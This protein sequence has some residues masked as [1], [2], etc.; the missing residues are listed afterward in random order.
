LR[1]TAATFDHRIRIGNVIFEHRDF[2]AV[3]DRRPIGNIERD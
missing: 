3:S 1:R 2:S